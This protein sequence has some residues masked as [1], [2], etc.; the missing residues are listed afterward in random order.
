MRA[1]SPSGE[2]PQRRLDD[3]G[4]HKTADK[5]PDQL[6]SRGVTNAVDGNGMFPMNPIPSGPSLCTG[7]STQLTRNRVMYKLT[8]GVWL[9]A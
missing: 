5:N 1:G 9:R 4:L 7:E 8:I 6:V 3:L 2:R